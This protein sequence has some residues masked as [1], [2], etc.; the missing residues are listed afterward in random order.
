MVFFSSFFFFKKKSTHVLKHAWFFKTF[1]LVLIF[2]RHVHRTCMGTFAALKTRNLNCRG[3]R[4]LHTHDFV[5]G[6]AT[7]VWGHTLCI[8]SWPFFFRRRGKKK[9]FFCFPGKV[10]TLFIQKLVGFQ[11]FYN[12]DVFFYKFSLLFLIIPEKVHMSMIHLILGLF[13]FYCWKKTV[14]QLF[15]QFFPKIYPYLTSR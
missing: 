14:F 11:L 6:S 9:M 1:F 7:L 12:K 3:Q 2:S 5:S 8:S 15:N 4:R 13:L 10:H